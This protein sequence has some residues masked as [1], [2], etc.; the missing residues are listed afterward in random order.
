M[1]RLLAL[2]ILVG[3]I[4]YTFYSQLWLKETQ[5]TVQ[6]NPYNPNENIGAVIKKGDLINE[7]APDFTLETLEGK[8]VTLSE[9]KGKKV[10]MNFWAS[11]CPPCLE[12]MPEIQ[13]FVDANPDIV[14][15]AIDFRNTEKSDE[16]VQEFITKNEYTFPVLLD[17]TG[18]IGNAYK[19]LTLPTSYFINT[20]GVIEYK[21][22]GP[23]NVDKITEI[24]Q[25][26]K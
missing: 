16:V 22:I 26:L 1:K 14:V 6:A 15:L 24:I 5:E 4:G 25:T 10:F 11:W 8:T 13:A 18:S 3:L 23:L 7:I 12:E 2:G 9:L 19:V 21:F 17:R 20:E